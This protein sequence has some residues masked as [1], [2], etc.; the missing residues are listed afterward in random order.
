MRTALRL[1]L[2]DEQVSDLVDRA[3][4]RVD[5]L[6]S[7]LQGSEWWHERERFERRAAS[8]FRDRLSAENATDSDRKIFDRSNKSLQTV[9]AINRFLEA[10]LYKDLFGA[11]PWFSVKP[12][13]RMDTVLA[14]QIQPHAAYKIREAK[15]DEI[16]KQI[17]KVTLDLGECPFIVTHKTDIDAH[18]RLALVLVDRQT[19]EPVIGPDGEPITDETPSEPVHLADPDGGMVMDTTGT[20]VETV[21]FAENL[22]LDPNL[23]EWRELPI[24][25]VTR[26]YH[27]PEVSLIHWR[28]LIWPVNVPCLQQADMV[29]RRYKRRLSELRAKYDP[30]DESDELREIFLEL[31]NVRGERETEASLAKDEHGEPDVP[32]NLDDPELDCLECYWDT[33]IEDDDGRTRSVR[34]FMVIHEGTRRCLWIDYRAHVCPRAMKPVFMPCINRVAGRA[35]GRGNY[36]MQEM[37]QDAS[38]AMLNGILYR[39]ELVTNPPTIWNPDKTEEGKDSPNLRY[40][41]GLRI[42]T[43]NSQVRPEDVFKVIEVPDLDDRTWN[44]MQLWMQVQQAETGVTNSAQA[45][46]SE[47]PGNDLATGINAL[48]EVA[49]IL[50]IYVL[51]EMKDGF[52]PGLGYFIALTYRNQDTDETYEFLE[53]E[54]DAVLALKDAAM[55]AKLP[56][57]VEITLARAKRQEQREGALASLP[58]LM[59]WETLPPEAQLRQKA[60]YEQ[61]LAGMGF[62]HPD[63]F[64]PTREEIMQRVLEGLQMEGYQL[65]PPAAPMETPM[66]EPGQP[67]PVDVPPA[68]ATPK[69]AIKSTY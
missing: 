66:G 22:W 31:E 67:A 40:G 55:L 34:L 2:S 41:P 1:E 29:A 28:D 63:D 44:L 53:G 27:G 35:Y 13:G 43:R 4:R 64:F 47:L 18:K 61:A 52:Q 33:I 49:S 37:S 19:G 15:W 11:K 68:P 59:Q 65:V 16:A 62:E 39:N 60:A 20:P 12:Q 46:V 54:A 14:N 42:R 26:L 25:E 56:L 10:R 23:H 3:I 7:D 8:D 51:E 36:E 5:D 48:A 21:Q 24:D 58:V 38:D 45:A 6:E 32:E 50:H 57:N 17:I 30:E 9:R 69:E